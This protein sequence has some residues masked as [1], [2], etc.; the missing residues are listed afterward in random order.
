MSQPPTNFYLIINCFYRKALECVERASVDKLKVCVVSII[1]RTPVDSTV[2]QDIISSLL[3]RK[4]TRGKTNQNQPIAT[5]SSCSSDPTGGDNF[6]NDGANPVE[7]NHVQQNANR[8]YENQV[9]GLLDTKASVIILQLSSFMDLN[10]LE[11]L[12]SNQKNFF[13]DETILHSWPQL[14]QNLVKT[15]LILYLLSHIVVIYSPEPS[16][17]AQS[18]RL[19][20]VLEDLRKRS[21]PRV[22]DLLEVLGTP[23]MFPQFWIKSGR[24]CCPRTL[25]VFDATHYPSNIDIGQAERNL[26]DHIYKLLRK[27]GIISKH[28]NDP[29]SLFCLPPGDNYVFLVTKK[30][31]ISCRTKNSRGE[32][33]IFDI[34]FYSSLLM[35]LSTKEERDM[36]HPSTLIEHLS[37]H[38]GQSHDEDVEH[39]KSS[40]ST[41]NTK[42]ININKYQQ[43]AAPMTGS[44]RFRKF[45]KLHI[46]QALRATLATSEHGS[47]NKSLTAGPQTRQAA[48]TLPRTDNFLKTLI[49]IK[50]L[51]FPSLDSASIAPQ[52]DNTNEANCD[53]W[54]TPD[55]RR[56]VDIYDLFDTDRVFSEIHCIKVYNAS[57]ELYIRGNPKV[58]DSKYHQEKSDLAKKFYAIHA[59]GSSYHTHLNKL[60]DQCEILWNDGRRLCEAVGCFLFSEKRN[61]T[62][63]NPLH[64]QSVSIKTSVPN[65]SKSK[66]HHHK[67]S[68]SINANNSSILN[69]HIAKMS[70]DESN[71]NNNKHNKSTFDNMHII[72]NQA[73]V[74]FTTSCEC[75]R[76]QTFVI[77]PKDKKKKLERIAIEKINTCADF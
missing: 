67:D 53:I 12:V 42:S 43:Q 16:F 63:N 32:K 48:F 51:L 72:R 61:S 31:L 3:G 73:G 23:Q 75:G 20:R 10:Q 35:Q 71:K 29:C 13:N 21:Q 18:I 54:R 56:F 44:N 52:Q 33:K 6:E 24:L 40:L 76:K 64:N 38:Q 5:D 9:I 17:D 4:T 69:P 47:S 49:K 70:H 55:E 22:C 19:F 65:G 27:S 62:C 77:T 14:N 30:D 74:R 26:E 34:S 28:N 2:K 25:F 1:G 37:Q 60:A 45:L 59:R 41:N 8:Q 11:F 50:N 66:Q 46:D 36:G 57:V 68:T 39:Q 58:Y 15:L 7:N